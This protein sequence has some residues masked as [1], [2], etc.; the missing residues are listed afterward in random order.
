M[1][2][3]LSVI[4]IALAGAVMLAACDGAAVSQTPQS[5]QSERGDRSERRAAFRAACGPDMQTY[6]PNVARDQ[7]RACIT[8]N[9]EKFSQACKTYMDQN[10][11]RGRRDRQG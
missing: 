5:G 3:K 7:R 11:W 9:R 10:P 6:C 1:T 2:L 4:G 8:A